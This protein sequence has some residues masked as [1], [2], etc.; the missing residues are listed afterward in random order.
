MAGSTNSF[1]QVSRWGA[2]YYEKLDT[3]LHILLDNRI[4]SS[5]RDHQWQNEIS[6]KIARE[7]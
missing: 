5:Q 2:K 1:V 3:S 4:D 7:R 6:E